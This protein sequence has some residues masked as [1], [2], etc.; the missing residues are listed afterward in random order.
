[1]SREATYVGYLRNG[2]ALTIPLFNLSAMEA[3]IIRLDSEDST[4]V[5]VAQNLIPKSYNYD[6]H[7]RYLDNP[8]AFYSFPLSNQ[9]AGAPLIPFGFQLSTASVPKENVSGRT[10]T[11]AVGSALTPGSYTV[12]R[13]QGY[14]LMIPPSVDLRDTYNQLSASDGAGFSWSWEGWIFPAT[15]AGTSLYIETNVAVTSYFQIRLDATLHVIVDHSGVAAFTSTNAL[16][17]VAW[18][19]VVL[20]YNGTQILFYLNNVLQQTTAYTHGTYSSI[21]TTALNFGPSGSHFS[22]S[23]ACYQTQLSAAAIQRHWFNIAGNDYE[24]GLAAATSSTLGQAAGVAVTAASGP[25]PM[26]TSP[27]GGTG[28]LGVSIPMIGVAA[29]TGTSG[30]AKSSW[31]YTVHTVELEEIS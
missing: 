13:L 14:Y 8:G 2:D 31:F 12:P 20:V 24:P 11:F 27:S 25:L 21:A 18:S 22:Q 3:M 15:S 16:P 26:L 5:V 6:T 1:M 4:G 9:T 17:I 19:H 7:V 29:I 23:I 28:I 10:C 30:S